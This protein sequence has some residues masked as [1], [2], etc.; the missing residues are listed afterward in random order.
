MSPSLWSETVHHSLP[1][2]PQLQGDISTEVLVIGGGMAGILCAYH[3]QRYG[4]SCVLAEG[5]TIG[6]GVTQN[7][8]AKITAQH[9]LLYDKMR[10]T[11]GTEKARQY[12]RAQT[13]AIEAFRQLS[14]QFP[15]DFE[16]K[17][18]YV[19][20]LNQRQKLEQ[21]AAA[22]ERLGIPFVLQENPPLPF[23]TAGAL[24]M[25]RQA[26]FHPLKLLY[27]LSRNLTIYENTLV[28]DIRDRCAITP[29]GRIRAKSILL[30]TH[31][32]MVNIP[33]LYFLKMYQHRSY[34]I[35]LEK[36]V[37]LGGMY[38]DEQ[39]KG[40]SFRNYQQFLLIGGG[41]H[42]TGKQ[43]GGWEELRQLAQN[44]Y[45]HAVE[46]YAWATQDCMTL[47][48]IPYIGRHRKSTPKLYVA[49]GFNK[50]GM[51][52]SMVAAQMLLDCV[53][54]KRNAYSPLFDPSR[55]ILHPQLFL[56]AAHA[57]G[58]LVSFGKRCSHMGCAL[59]WNPQ[60]QTWDCSCHGSR[61]NPEGEVADNPAKKGI[62][63]AK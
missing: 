57:V 51:T 56:N 47:D 54:E 58:G 4:L 15:C 5:H 32:P 63:L 55:R 10:R 34:V 28:T 37:S 14:I 35:A 24:G 6:S 23:Q 21:E 11:Y 44:A 30:T 50:W 2:H 53:T 45:P 29:H 13:E 38:L 39:E 7:T 43:G 1:R 12:Y 41:D 22:Y 26:Q 46:R 19:Y 42:R 27:G 61:F 60:E 17:I 31:F 25:P 52:G 59:R 49:T 18:A 48:G 16:E 33:G 20:S 62:K 8:T 3:L 40:H 9:G 36:A